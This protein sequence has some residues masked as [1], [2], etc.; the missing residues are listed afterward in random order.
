MNAL[1]DAGHDVIALG[2]ISDIFDG[3]GVTQV[4]R[5]VSNSDGMDKF[6]STFD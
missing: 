3:E 5:T 1:K 4:I 6:I 2:K